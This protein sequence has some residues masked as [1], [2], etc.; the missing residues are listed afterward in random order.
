MT[1]IDDNWMTSFD[2][3]AD[4][5]IRSTSARISFNRSDDNSLS[6]DSDQRHCFEDPT[7]H[8]CCLKPEYCSTHSILCSY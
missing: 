2:A 8:T 7:Y 1:L 3:I 4:D 5:G 6:Y